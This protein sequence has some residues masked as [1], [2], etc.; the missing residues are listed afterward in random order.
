[1]LCAELERLEAE[2]DDVITDLEKPGLTERQRKELDA[3]YARLAREMNEHRKA[4]HQG[5]PCYEE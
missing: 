5:A 4:G 3:V 1:M 2:L